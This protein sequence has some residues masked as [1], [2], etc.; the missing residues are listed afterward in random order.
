MP[1]TCLG[2]TLAGGLSQVFEMDQEVCSC[3]FFVV[4]VLILKTHTL[5]HTHTLSLTHTLSH[6]HTHTRFTW[7]RFLVA[8]KG[9]RER[10]TLEQM[11]MGVRIKTHKRLE[12]CF[13]I[14]RNRKEDGSGLGLQEKMSDDQDEYRL[15]CKRLQL[16][17]SC[18]C[19]CSYLLCCKTVM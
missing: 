5:T 7:K 8:C 11:E 6:T 9:H 16:P 17:G 1:D 3:F 18:I 13:L 2:A 19:K 15:W 14:R 12:E 10:E 4:F